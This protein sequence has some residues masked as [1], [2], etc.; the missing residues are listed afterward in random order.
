MANLDT[1]VAKAH[2]VRGPEEAA[3]H[4]A[5][6][7]TELGLGNYTEDQAAQGEEALSVLEQ[8]F[9][10]VRQRSHDKVAGGGHTPELSRRAKHNLDG[11]EPR[12]REEPH[13][14]AGT[15]RPSPAAP[16]RRPA[17]SR[18]RSWG[19]NAW[20]QTGIPSTTLSASQL[21]MRT[22]GG[23]AGL[24]FLYLLLSPRGSRAV[25]LTGSGITHSLQALVN[26]AVDPF[27]VGS[28]TK[29]AAPA[30]VRPPTTNLPPLTALPLATPPNLRN[31]NNP[32]G[33]AITS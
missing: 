14:R 20:Q 12:K 15:R 28:L 19:S 6:V 31:G 9:P 5:N 3:R 2:R 32:R 22:L 33:V 24:S 1:A 16:G 13:P 18:S 17:R 27:R 10:G 26:P 29:A 30:T 25:S 23:I 8:R 4:Y 21:A 11:P 7:D